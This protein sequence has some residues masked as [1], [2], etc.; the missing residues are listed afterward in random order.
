MPTQEHAGTLDALREAMIASIGRRTIGQF[1][2]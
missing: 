1:D 2:C